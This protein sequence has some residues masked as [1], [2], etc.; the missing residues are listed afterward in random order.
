MYVSRAFGNHEK[1]S[2][3]RYSSAFPQKDQ[4]AVHWCPQVRQSFVMACKLPSKTSSRFLGTGLKNLSWLNTEME[5]PEF[6]PIWTISKG[7]SNSCPEKCS[8][9]F[10]LAGCFT[11]L[12]SPVFAKMPGK[13]GKVIWNEKSVQRGRTLAGWLLYAA[14]SRSNSCSFAF[15]PLEYMKDL[16]L[17]MLFDRRT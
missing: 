1:E 12:T 5:H 8:K 13:V 2:L 3:Q 7:F 4:S 10:Q 9:K 14:L 17:L 15:S 16:I 11:L 6:V